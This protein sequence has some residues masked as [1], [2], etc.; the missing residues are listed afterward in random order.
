VLGGV[1]SLEVDWGTEEADF[2]TLARLSAVQFL[3]IHFHSEAHPDSRTRLWN[4]TAVLSDPANLSRLQS[5]SVTAGAYNSRN[6][7]RPIRQDYV[8]ALRATCKARGIV[9]SFAHSDAVPLAVGVLYPA[10]P[11]HPLSGSMVASFSS[12]RCL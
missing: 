10:V 8:D 12:A 1:T 4:L 2:S 9:F 3:S 11:S 5:L 7:A 6:R